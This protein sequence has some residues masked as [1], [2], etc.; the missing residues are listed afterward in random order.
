MCTDQSIKVAWIYAKIAFL[1]R[2][3]FILFVQKPFT[4]FYELKRGV[5]MN[6]GE[7]LKKIRKINNLTQEQLA[8]EIYYSCQSVSNW[9]RN[10]SVPPLQIMLYLS[11]K[12]GFPINDFLHDRNV[13]TDLKKEIYDISILLLK[14][15]K[16]L[17]LDNL[18]I[19]SNVDQ[20]RLSNFINNDDQLVSFVIREF[21]GNIERNIWKKIKSYESYYDFIINYI[22]YLIYDNKEIVSLFYRYEYISSIWKD[23]LIEKYS[24]ILKDNFST[25][26]NYKL[27]VKIIIEVFQDWLTDETILNVNDFK[28]K[29]KDILNTRI[30]FL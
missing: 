22:I 12:Y 15:S 19:F 27:F 5:D 21:E 1:R 18:I 4:G 20:Y 8:E 11:K 6:I 17:S 28:E 10:R 30:M 9:E 14:K 26:N 23:Y 24:R 25:D 29:L 13:D 3:Y 2:L 16:K 7:H